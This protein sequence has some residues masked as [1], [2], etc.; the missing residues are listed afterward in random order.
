MAGGSRLVQAGVAGLLGSPPNSFGILSGFASAEEAVASAKLQ[1]DLPDRQAR[2]GGRG[3]KWR[4][5]LPGDE[6]YDGDDDGSLAWVRLASP[7]RLR[8]RI[9]GPT[10]TD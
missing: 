6:D 3:E 5:L 1:Q 7:S 2:V 8:S 9:Q 4:V 10:A